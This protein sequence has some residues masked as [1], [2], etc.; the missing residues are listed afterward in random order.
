M[1]LEK[2]LLFQNKKSGE[3]FYMLRLSSRTVPLG[4][5][6]VVAVGLLGRDNKHFEIDP[7][8]LFEPNSEWVYRG[9]RV[10][11]A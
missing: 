9:G 7:D 1:A 4:P 10:Y 8:R 11:E 3:M 2:S 6:R 5:R